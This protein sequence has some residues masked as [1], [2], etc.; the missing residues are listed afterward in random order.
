[1]AKFI[2]RV[3]TAPKL[4]VRLPDP[5]P[6]PEDPPADVGNAP[7]AEALSAARKEAARRRK[8]RSSLRIPL[9]A[10]ANSG[11]SGGVQI[12]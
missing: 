1:M 10:S 2:K 4:K 6:A 7:D 11:G 8:N 3:F 5:Q 9:G 12:S